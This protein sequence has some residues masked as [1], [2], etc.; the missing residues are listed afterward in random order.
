MANAANW[1]ILPTISNVRGHK[2]AQIVQEKEGICSPQVVKIHLGPT[3]APFGAGC[4]NSEEKIRVNLDLECTNTYTELLERIDAWV[5]DTLAAS[6]ELY[7]KKPLTRDEV[8][9]AYKPSCTPHSKNGI[10]YSP[11]MRCKTTL[12]GPSKVRCWTPERFLR[13]V[14]ED[15]R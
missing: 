4:F 12:E 6:P 7:F 8:I 14:P 10:D 2:S 5:I 11:T 1:K 3:R 9:K 15:W 13:A